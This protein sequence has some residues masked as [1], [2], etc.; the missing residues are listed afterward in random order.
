MYILINRNIIHL[1]REP[2]GRLAYPSTR[3]EK[4]GEHYGFYRIFGIR[5]EKK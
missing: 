5:N 3:I 2:K 1:A 4:G